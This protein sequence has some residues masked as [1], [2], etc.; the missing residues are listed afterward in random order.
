M[1]TTCEIPE[2]FD[3]RQV[4]EDL[5]LSFLYAW[6]KRSGNEALI[7]KC[8]PEIC[9]RFSCICKISG[10]EGLDIGERTA[11]GRVG[12]DTPTS[13]SPQHCHAERSEASAAVSLNFR[14]GGDRPTSAPK[15]L[16]C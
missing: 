5:P 15:A 10:G 3:Q 1:G 12:G 14:I 7:G 4:D 6:F 8:A 2:I 11:K 13:N 16:S 9:S